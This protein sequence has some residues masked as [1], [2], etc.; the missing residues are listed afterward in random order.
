MEAERVWEIS[1]P[2]SQF[3]CERETTLKIILKILYHNTVQIAFQCILIYTYLNIS[4][5]EDT[6][7]SDKDAQFQIFSF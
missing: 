6:L 1:V 7:G 5:H 3:C 2:S 4:I